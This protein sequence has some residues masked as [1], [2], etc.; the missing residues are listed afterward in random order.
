[1]TLSGNPD[2]LATAITEGLRANLKNAV[3]EKLS[4][5]I[6]PMLTELAEEL[7][8]QLVAKVYAIELSPMEALSSGAFGLN[9]K[10]QLILNIDGIQ[11]ATISK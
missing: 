8:N 5:Q 2:L 1:M 7:A 6:K 10:I 3:F 11:H 4:D 9:S